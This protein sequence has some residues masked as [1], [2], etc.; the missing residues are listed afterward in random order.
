MTKINNS[1]DNTSAVRRPNRETR[2]NKSRKN[3]PADFGNFSLIGSD[4]RHEIVSYGEQC[5]NR[6]RGSHK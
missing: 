2:R 3:R 4:I 6:R 1:L 5:N